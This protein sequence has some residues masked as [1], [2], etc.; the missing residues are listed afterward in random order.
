[1]D[2]LKSC[3]P[4]NNVQSVVNLFEQQITSSNPNLAALSI[5]AGFLENKLTS[6]QQKGLNFQQECFP[7]LEWD[8]FDTLL[9]RFHRLVDSHLV[10]LKRPSIPPGCNDEHEQEEETNPSR[11]S[12]QEA[13]RANE[14][15]RGHVK[16]ISDFVWSFL[17]TSFSKDRPHL[18]SVYN[19]LNDKRLD[20]FG[21]AFSV[22]AIAQYLG[23]DEIHLALSE[24]HAWVRFGENVNETSEI[25]WHGKSDKEKRGNPVN[26][27]NAVEFEKDWLYLGGHEV[28]CDRYMEVA[29]IVSALNPGINS[30]TDSETVGRIQQELLWMLYKAG[31]LR[32]Y[33]MAICNLADLEEIEQTN[34][35]VGIEDLYQEAIEISETAYDGYHVYPYTYYGG[36]LF[37]MEK[38]NR[39]TEMWCKAAQTASRFTHS[40][41][42]EELYKDLH[43][44]ANTFFP[45][46]IKIHKASGLSSSEQRQYF[47]SSNNFM[48]ILNFYDYCCLWEQDGYTSAIHAEWAKNFNKIISSFSLAIRRSFIQNTVNIQGTEDMQKDTFPRSEKMELMTNII[49]QEKINSQTINLH[50]TSRLGL[51]TGKYFSGT[52]KSEK[53][54]SELMLPS[55]KRAKRQ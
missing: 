23:L 1:M 32:R 38:F 53:F 35:E 12:A 50:L 9:R 30:K 31:H 8:E 44:I 54:A 15:Q 40:Q 42:D 55:A 36:Y 29:A 21:I 52:K 48:H 46:I 14:K 34:N 20:C 41:Q 18:Q 6:R 19:F 49:S 11:S 37:R 16:K 7:T 28:K 33:P 2:L 4:L 13:A 24:D 22:V 26:T 39:A 17:S 5:V 43:E 27:D 3:F 47:E 45:N 10:S 51:R 25:T